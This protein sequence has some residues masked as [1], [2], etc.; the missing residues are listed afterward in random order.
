MSVHDPLTLERWRTIFAMW[1]SSG[2]SVAAFC[3]SR[4]LNTSS[5]YRWR[6]ICDDLG[7][8]PESRP[9]QSFVPV[10]VVPDTIVEL[11]LPTGVH[12]RVPLAAD[13]G[14]VARLV[15]ALVA[16]SC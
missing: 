3:R 5:F 16:P 14:Q 15:H 9:P 1:R 8:T 10:R 13:A 2:L 4:S 7:R 6:N 11:I 12:L